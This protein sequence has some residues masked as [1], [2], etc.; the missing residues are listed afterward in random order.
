VRRR[1][2]AALLGLLALAVACGGGSS[3]PREK[4]R[5][6]ILRTEADDQRVG[7]EAS[8]Q[9]EAEMGL[10][11]DPALLSYVRQIGK[12]LAHYA[13]RGRFEYSFQIV[14][15]EA[16]NAF[17][18]PGGHIYVSRGL[19]ALS[20]SEDELAGVIGHEIVHVARR[21]AA[22]RQSVMHSVPGL[23]Q[24]SAAG[25]VASYSRNQEREA[26]RLGQGLAG[27]AGYDP[28]GIAEFLTSLE[29]T[30]RL[31]IGYSRLPGFLDTHPATSERV[32]SAGARA[33]MIAWK[34]K[35]PLAPDRAAYLAKLDGL[36][37]GTRASEGVFEGDRFLHGDMGFAMRFPPGWRRF[38]TRQAVGAVS[39]SRDAQVALEFQG[40]G[41]DVQAA[42]AQFIAESSGGGLSVDPPRPIKIGSLDAMRAEGRARVRGGSV[43]A[44]F[45]WITWQGSVFRL[46][47]M[48]LGG[49][50]KLE[51]VFR[52]VA[53][54]FRPITPQERASI[55][56]RRL[57]IAT[58]RGGESIGELSRRTGNEWDIQRTAV[59]N[60]IFATARLE[61]GQLMKIAVSEGAGPAR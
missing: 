61:S 20:N 37:L 30:E 39:P 19:L 17:A 4:K 11:R 25:M 9:V 5:E 43:G 49:S 1:L 15:Q 32:A 26:D 41:D 3:P 18:L 13:P 16:P 7:E 53:R 38:N 12:R 51:G 59:M 6:V 57:R 27:L 55:S 42:A 23:F 60:G 29:Y 58:A 14:D 22:G 35:P 44:H 40:R 46:T 10:I 47:G 28:Q 8:K 33:R 52:S 2:A 21:H 36:A 48:A 54:S 45:T 50:S 34:R 24:M 56:E 31:R